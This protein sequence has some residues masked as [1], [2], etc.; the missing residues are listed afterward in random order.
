MRERESHLT[1]EDLDAW[2][3]GM[4]SAEK[5]RELLAHVGAC[6]HCAELLAA[7]LERDSVRPPAYLRE[8]ILEKSRSPQFQT[9]RTVRRVSGRMRLF[10]YSLKVGAALAVSL[11]MLFVLPGAKMPEADLHRYFLEHPQESVTE[12]LRESGGRLELLLDRLNVR[13]KFMEYEENQ[14][15]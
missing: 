10:L 9:V 15:D 8:E 3:L 5:E 6:N 11:L 13:P 14:N 7:Y 1:G 2:I 12:K 4:L